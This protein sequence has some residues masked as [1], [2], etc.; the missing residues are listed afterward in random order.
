MMEHLSGIDAVCTI[1]GSIVSAGTDLTYKGHV[2]K[3]IG[4]NMS[5]VTMNEDGSVDVSNALDNPRNYPSCI[6]QLQRSS[7]DLLMIVGK[8]DK[9]WQS[10]LFADIAKELMESEGKKN[11]KIIKYPHSGHF[12]DLPNTP[13]VTTTPHVLVPNR[14]MVYFGGKNR[15]FFQ[16]K[17]RCLEADT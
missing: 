14:L 13:I 11:Y 5:K 9:I 8:D 4:A 2:T 3:M 10:E 6:N 1:N 15:H 16:G 12:F 7:A 17:R